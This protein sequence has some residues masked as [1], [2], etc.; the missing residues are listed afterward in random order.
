M[1]EHLFA[2]S[3]SI[4]RKWDIERNGV[5]D[6]NGI[7]RAPTELLLANIETFLDSIIF[8]YTV[9]HMFSGNRE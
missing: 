3:A 1:F 5:M 2:Y 6:V 7:Y 9:N 4:F 8:G